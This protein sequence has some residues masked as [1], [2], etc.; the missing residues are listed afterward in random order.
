[1]SLTRREFVAAS[2][3]GV[4]GEAAEARRPNILFLMPDQHRYHAVGCLGNPDVRTPHLDRLAAE[5]VIL[6]H[7]FA[8]T[9]VCCPARSVLLTGQYCHRNGMVAN[10]LR[11]REG[12]VSFAQTLRDAGYRTGFVGKWHLDGGPREPGFVPPGPRR[13]GFE[14]WAAHQCSHRHFDNH[15]FRD[16]AEPIKLGK[17]E[18]EG[19]ADLGVE[20]LEATKTDARPFYLT[21]QW[22]PPH[23][24]YKAPAS[25]TKEYEPAKLAMRENYAAGE[26]V[27]TPELI[28]EYYGMVTAID[29][30]VGRLMA[31]LD[32]LGLRENTIVL[33][34]S[35]HGDMLGSQG[36]RLKRKPW[37]ES[38][39]VPGI[40][41]WPG[42]V[43]AKTRSDVFF[44]H[45]DF[46]PTLLG[47]AGVPVPKAMQGRDLSG[48]IVK[49]KG[50]GPDS[51]FFQIFGPFAGDGTGA[52]WRGVRTATHMYARY[53]D[54]PWVLYDLRKDPFQRTNLV[55]EAG[56]AGVQRKLERRLEQWMKETGDSWSFNWT[57]PVEDGG[58]LYKHRTF[59]TVGEYLEWAKQNP[60]LDAGG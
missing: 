53:E 3:A 12:S 8:N 50:R 46:A 39:R 45:V 4:S 23:D 57:H 25:Y 48:P 1:M 38:V 37:E 21:V 5:G 30:Q 20:F 18:A 47:M 49:G 55:G 51:A 16:E 2:A 27:P 36:A 29:D 35:D 19:W 9:P 40:L 33:Y 17:F 54:R 43:A 6:D 60:K 58:R 10:D 15:Y 24:P 34:S 41:R 14:F 56:S 32:E 59:Y 31:K 11:L 22:G 44:T 28:A 42:K 7:V 13:Q 52:G 26:R